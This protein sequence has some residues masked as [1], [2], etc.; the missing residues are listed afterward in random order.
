MKRP[1]L[2]AAVFLP[3]F[4]AAGALAQRG[5]QRVETADDPYERVADRRDA[6]FHFIR[7]EYTDLPQFHRR[8]GF[9]SR[10]GQGASASSASS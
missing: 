9:A 1:W 4:L 6:E 2:V 5:F 7:L 8:F 3:L 10:D